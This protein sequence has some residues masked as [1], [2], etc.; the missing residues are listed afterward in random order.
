MSWDV[1]RLAD[2]LRFFHHADAQRM[3]KR[4][5]DDAVQGRR[6]QKADGI[7][8]K[9]APKLD[10]YVTPEIRALHAVEPSA[11]EPLGQPHHTLARAAGGCADDQPT[12]GV[13]VDHAW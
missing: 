8:A 2:P 9:I 11:A 1:D 3:N 4:L 10:P 5:V 6:G 12:P 7:R 13:H